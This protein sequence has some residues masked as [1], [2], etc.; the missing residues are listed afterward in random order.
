M[1][2]TI[3]T[4]SALF[5]LALGA[6]AHAAAIA[7]VNAGF[8]DPYLGSNLPP[9]YAGDV[10]PTAFPVGPAPGGWSAF[11]AT[12]NGAS[13]GV[14]NPGVAGVDPGASFFPG[15]APE[16]D[17]VALLYANGA[18]SGAEFG[19]AQTLVATLQAHT[20]YTLEVDVG[21]IASGTST[22]PLLFAGFG[23]FNLDGF[24][25]YR[26]D[27]LAGSTLV[28]QDT[29]GVSPG[30]GEFL[31]STLQW[32][33]GAAPVGFGEALSI[34][35]VNLRNADDP[36]ATGLEVDFDNVRLDAA[37]VPLP[38]G[39]ALF[40]LPLVLGLRRRRAG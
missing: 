25:G 7:I 21:N 10:P 29:N 15:G 4:L 34:R 36:A 38:P 11:G 40:G 3:K 18:G 35:L 37:P 14:L 16:G 9:I 8:E 27:V 33:T 23:F 20:R 31:T 32:T 39:L 6:P 24:P 1:H 22:E 13:I 30:E 26:I 12:G 28:A 5:A 17:N 19:I 2:T